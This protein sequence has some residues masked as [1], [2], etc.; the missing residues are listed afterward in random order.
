[1]I[2]GNS[3]VQGQVGA[4]AGGREDPG[5]AGSGGDFTSGGGDAWA[6]A[7]LGNTGRLR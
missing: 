1:M 5:T 7:A 3:V 4:V 2:S 6:E